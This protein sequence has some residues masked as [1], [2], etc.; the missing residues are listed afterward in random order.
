MLHT[1]G[2]WKVQRG[3][4]G[5]GYVLSV[6]A[7]KVAAFGSAQIPNDEAVANSILIAAAP[8]LLAALIEI[9]DRDNK[10]GSLPEAYR[11]I[12]DRALSPILTK[13]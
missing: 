1:P 5:Y 11:S 7:T 2:P 4:H 8:D 3:A 12:V 6:D 13:V 10:N 9:A